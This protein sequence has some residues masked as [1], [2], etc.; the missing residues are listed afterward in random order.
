MRYKLV[1]PIAWWTNSVKSLLVRQKFALA[2]LE[3]DLDNKIVLNVD[4]TWL[5]MS[6]FRR[7]KWRPHRH[8]NSVAQLQ[9]APRISMIVGIDS[10]GEVFLSLVQSNS[11]SKTMMLFFK[12]LILKLDGLR[13]GWRRSHII[14][15][16]N[17]TYHKSSKMLKFFEDY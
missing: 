2:F 16:D 8:T 9:L 15:L 5:G 12:H 7:R 10:L 3:I 14:L 11:N 17:A 13:Q 1:K 6:D 4:E